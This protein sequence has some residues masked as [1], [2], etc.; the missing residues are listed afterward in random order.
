MGSPET[1]PLSRVEV[2]SEESPIEQLQGTIPNR[3]FNDWYQQK[4]VED[5]ILHG[6]AYFNG[7]SPSK[8]PERHAP[9]ELRQCHRKP[10]TTA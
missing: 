7:L 9:N 8:P 4:K 2:Y 3:Y 1:P 6:Q 5:N 10:G